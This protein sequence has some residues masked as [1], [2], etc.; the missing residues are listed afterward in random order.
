[1]KWFSLSKRN[2]A[3]ID[4]T[5]TVFSFLEYVELHIVLDCYIA[6]YTKFNNIHWSIKQPATDP[7]KPP[8]SFQVATA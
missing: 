2:V 3:S 8:G 7:F 6:V 4:S 5:K 1:M